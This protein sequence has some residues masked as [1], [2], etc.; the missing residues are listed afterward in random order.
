M[1]DLA[2][3]N[4]RFSRRHLIA[5]SL[6]LGLGGS[7]IKAS[8]SAIRAHA[9][10]NDEIKHLVWV[11]QFST[12]AEP[13][14]IAKKLNPFNLGVVLK[15]HDGDQWMSEYDTS[16]YAV[17]GPPQIA[18]LANFFESQGVPFHA[19]CVVH[20]ADPQKEAKMAA[21]VL[22]AGARSIFLDIEPHSGFWRGTKDDA[23]AYGN[24]LR[25]QQPNGHVV[26]SIDPRPWMINS[27]PMQELVAFSDELAPQQYWRTF[28]TSANFTKY[29]EN[30]YPVPPDGM[31]PEFLLS[32]TNTL[33]AGYGKPISQVGQGAT[34]TVDEWQRFIKASYANGGSFVSLWRYGVTN[35]GIL[36]VL[37]DNP[38]PQP[39]PV[40]AAA[41][42]H[43]VQSGDTLGAIAAAYGTTVDEL[44][45]LNGLTD[46][47]YLYVGQVLALPGGSVVQATG[48]QQSAPAG[49]SASSGPRT[50]T[51]QSGDTLYGIAGQFGTSVDAIVQANGLS[52]PNYLSVGQ[53][54]TIP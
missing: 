54:L 44:M 46:P 49:D 1:H 20:G 29:A 16:P 33:F 23:V 2:A 41:A 3:I 25:S 13:D 48:L 36:G 5:A 6:A 12:D 17:S 27:L 30:G 10:S 22:G 39:P 37:R 7:L 15:T 45:S 40:Q 19:W 53:V 31:S 14:V 38:P 21:D 47:N 24:E 11:W 50:Y 9:S 18:V 34:E 51:V 4:R 26:L 8:S 28:D 52:D 32:L 35:D 43:V 42:T